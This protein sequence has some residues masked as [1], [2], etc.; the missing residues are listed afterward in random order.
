[1]AAKD[2]SVFCVVKSKASLK[3]VKLKEHLISSHLKNGL[4]NVDSFCSKKDRFEKSGTLPK[5]VFVKTQKPC[6]KHLI[7]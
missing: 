3:S 7:R 6:V 1:M 2:H 5:F 4:D